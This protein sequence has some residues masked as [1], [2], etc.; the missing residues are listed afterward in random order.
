MDSILTIRQPDAERVDRVLTERLFSG[1]TTLRLISLLLWVVF[2]LAYGGHAPWWMIAAP[3]ALH[4]C[5]ILGFIWLSN[6]H[7]EHPAARSNEGWRRLYI[8][9]AGVT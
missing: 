6:A 3:A 9:C 8:L 2:A 4:V 1:H 7:R 5:T